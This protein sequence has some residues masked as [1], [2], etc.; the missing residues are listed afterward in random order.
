MTALAEKFETIVSRGLTNSRLRDYYDLWL[1]PTLRG[2]DGAEVSAALAATFSHRGTDLP[3]V[4][5]A[6]LTD[7]FSGSLEAQAAWRAF[8]SSRRI[9]AP[10]DFPSVCEA[11]ANFSMP[12]SAVAAAGEAFELTWDSGTGWM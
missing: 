9:D 7:A 3:A 6:G 12:P 11:I 2:F 1:L 8:L 5:P 10:E 4:P